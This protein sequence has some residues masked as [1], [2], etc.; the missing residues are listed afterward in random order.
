M[1]EDYATILL[2]SIEEMRIMNKHDH[3]IWQGKNG[4]WFTY[5]N[6]NCGRKLLKRNT[7]EELRTCIAKYYRELETNPTVKDLFNEWLEYKMGMHDIV[8]GT[9]DHYICDYN[10]FIRGKDFEAL[11]VRVIDDED[12][13]ILVRSVISDEITSKA[14]ANFRTVLSG[15]F[16]Y[17]K[18]K[19]YTNISISSYLKDLDISRKVFKPSR[20]NPE[21]AVFSDDEAKKLIDYLYSKPTVEHLGIVLVFESGIRVGELSALKF[22]DISNGI[23][24]VQR[25]EIVYKSKE[26]GHMISE[27]VNYTKTEAGDRYIYLPEDSVN[28]LTALRYQVRNE[29]DYIMWKNG[30]RISKKMFYEYLTK[31]CE[32]IDIPKRSMHKIR[33]TYATKLIDSDVE[34]SLIMSQMGHS[35]I[36]TTRKYYYYCNKNNDYKRDQIRKAIRY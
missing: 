26:A 36:S 20:K 6:S 30:H 16:R 14:F 15:M 34:D 35:D 7:F 23:M 25:Q 11:R 17:A 18:R 19:G 12:F 33:S 29:E 1:C 3:K 13:D 28:I 4:K 8:P 5:V 22:S 24:H 32:A 21:T 10:R 27:V 31:A 9:K 2:E